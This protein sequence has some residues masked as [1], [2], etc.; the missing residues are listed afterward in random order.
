M[1]IGFQFLIGRIEIVLGEK[2][3]DFASEFQFLIGRIEII[4]SILCY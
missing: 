2:N 1:Y 4:F 3:L